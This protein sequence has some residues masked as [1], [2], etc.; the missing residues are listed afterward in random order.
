MRILSLGRNVINGVKLRFLSSKVHSLSSLPNCFPTLFIYIPIPDSYSLMIQSKAK[1]SNFRF[2]SLQT[3]APAPK[4]KTQFS[5]N[6]ALLVQF[7][8]SSQCQAA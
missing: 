6:Q 8:E 2:L 1:T 5:H 3:N 4:F 7:L